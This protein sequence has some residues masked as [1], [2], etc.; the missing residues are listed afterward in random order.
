MRPRSIEELACLEEPE[1]Y[2]DCGRGYHGLAVLISRLESP[3]QYG[4]HRFLVQTEAGTLDHANAPRFS[5]SIYFN[6]QHDNSRVFR[7]ARFFGKFRFHFFDQ[8]WSGDAVAG[9]RVGGDA[10]G[11]LISRADATAAMGSD[12]AT[13]IVTQ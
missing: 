12:S 10:G 13:A 8:L 7:L 5:V 9:V 4:V 3:L 2:F 1:I 11:A 6:L